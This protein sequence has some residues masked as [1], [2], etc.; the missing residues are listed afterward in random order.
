MT[1]AQRLYVLIGSAIIGLVG[2]AMLG[3][4]QIESVYNSANYGNINSVPSLT[5]LDNMRKNYLRVR[6]Q[7]NRH[8]LNSD[9]TKMAE[10]EE[11]LKKNRQGVYDAMKKYETDGCNGIPCFADDKEKTIF[12]NIKTAWSEF[13]PKLDPILVESRADHMEKARDMM[14]TTLAAS[15]KVATLIDDDFDYNIE[16]AKKGSND[17]ANAKSSAVTLSITIALI[18]I[19][20]VGVL[21]WLIMLE[22]TRPLN[23]AIE[24]ANT[25]ADGDLTVK[26]DVTS[27]DEFGHLLSSLQNMVTKL[28]QV[29]SEVNSSAANIASASEEVSATAQNM[30]Q[31][32]A[33]QAAS[34]EETSASIEQMSASINQNTENAK[35]TD[36]MATQASS[37]AVRGGE[38]VSETVNAMKSIAGKIGIIDDIAYQTNLLA[39]NAAIEAARAGEHGKG[40]AVV[41]A[42]VR[43]LAERS[44]IAAQEIGQLA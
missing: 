34:V 4:F 27:K 35:V 6:I 32:S 40:F 13:D 36:G 17:A 30:S 38:A 7:S 39:L 33:E 3:Y 20:I 9:A 14:A 15:E 12:D 41:A 44:Q 23:Q 2:L 26:I 24:V 42:E 8:I 29:I 18:V 28:S 10:I 5:L 16:L 11:V 21:S 19:A 43:K 22:I 25:L 1:V 37:E 31:A